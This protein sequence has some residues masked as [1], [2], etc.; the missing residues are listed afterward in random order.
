MVPVL[1]KV[2]KT[3]Y[4]QAGLLPYL[5][6]ES[7]GYRVLRDRSP[8]QTS[9]TERE[10]PLLILRC[11]GD[12]AGQVADALSVFC[13]QPLTYT[14][15]AGAQVTVD[16]PNILHLAVT[17]RPLAKSASS[18]AI[19]ETAAP[20]ATAAETLTLREIWQSLSGDTKLLGAALDAITRALP[21]ELVIPIDQGEELLTQVNSPMQQTRRQ[22]ALDMLMQLAGTAAR[23]KIVFTLRS[24]Y[25]GQLL[26]L[27][28][29]DRM[30]AG[31]HGFYL[32]PLTES[33]M[34]DA[35]LWPTNRDEVPYG[36]DV[37]YLRYRFVF[38]EGSAQQIVADAIEAADSAGHG[39]LPIVQAAGALLYQKQV[40][41]KRQQIV[42]VGDLK[43]SGG[44][45]N[46]LSKY[47]D[48]AVLKLPHGKQSQAALRTL[49]G[50]LYTSH[51]DGTLSRDLAPASDLKDYWHGST[52]VE[53]IVDEAA[54]KLGLFDIQR[55]FIGGEADTYVSLAQ[56]SLARLGRTIDSERDMEAYGK[57]KIIDTLWVMIP[58]AFLC[59]TLTFCL[60]R[61]YFPSQAGPM[62]AEIE[63]ELQTREQ[64]ARVE[65]VVKMRRPIYYGQLAQAE[66]ALQAENAVRARQI[67][68]SQPAMISF[69][70]KKDAKAA[71]LRGFEW[72]YLWKNLNGER[73]ALAGQRG[74]VNAVAVK[75]Q[76]V[77]TAGPTTESKN[78]GTIRIWNRSTGQVIALMPG[79]AAPVNALAFSHN[80]KLL[81]SAG[82]DKVVRLWDLSNFKDN[83]YIEI[84]KE[85]KV[86]NGHTD[87]VLA[88]DIYP[89]GE[90]LASASADKSVILWDV[91]SGKPRHT[92]K[93]H[94]AAVNAVV[95]ESKKTLAS[96]G[97]DGQLILWDTENGKKRQAIK[98]E[99]QTIAALA[100]PPGGK[101]VATGG[102]EIKDGV[103]Q[104]TIRLWQ[105]DDGKET[106][107]PI[108]HGASVR[109][110][111]YLWGPEPIIVSGGSDHVLRAFNV[112]TGK[113]IRRW[114]GHLGEI[115]SV[116]TLGDDIVTGSVDG[117][118]KVWD[119]RHASGP[120]VLHAHD[121]WVQA[122][123]LHRKN[124]LLA[125]GARDG[126]VKLWDPVNLRMLKELPKH[127]GAVTSVAFSHHGDR[128]LLAVGTR[129]AKNEGEI[130]IWQ[131]DIETATV[132]DINTLKEHTK[133]I[134][135]LA[136]NPH[137]DRADVL[138][139]GSAD[140]TVKVW[141]ITTGKAKTHARHKDE[142]RCVAFDADGKLFG[143]GGKDA[144]VCL[145]TLDKDQAWT[146]PDLHLNSVESI[147][148]VPTGITEQV[149]DLPIHLIT[150][151]ADLT[152]KRSFYFMVENGPAEQKA[153]LSS[154]PHSQPI[155]SALHNGA[156][157][158]D[159]LVTASWD[160][161][162]KL[163][164]YANERFTLL[165][166]HGAVRGIA[167][168]SDQSFLAS[169]GNDGTLRFWRAD[170][171]RGQPKDG[172]K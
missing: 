14:T 11:T 161:T 85:T 52:P 156:G 59:A 153:V 122:V 145:Y 82:A 60:T 37:P 58:L 18:T 83:E 80:A 140:H 4:L 19:Q 46:A 168:A 141:D 97:A 123:A 69:L 3:S 81:A 91:S 120:Q 163:Y 38:E 57:S 47:F 6:Q 63:K 144:L 53:D 162:I 124:S 61:N 165:G 42:R 39:P 45:R 86:L 142:V 160:G 146:I 106:G 64:Q 152:F 158:S 109:A 92:L 17:G 56:D 73:H 98:T 87:A 115:T 132:K 113:Q 23:C 8:Q 136:F 96:A 147:L 112:D 105:V 129:N 157:T 54:E 24:Q 149:S 7:V 62:E 119:S 26:S 15:P 143:S 9:V 121:D 49:I 76:Y 107:K 28:P 33:E 90:T 104:G 20:G 172:K 114:L 72:R 137:A 126:T 1:E 131:L 32:R 10:Y 138:L 22:K 2:G 48:L 13:A 21:F 36:D 93:E 77:A 167:M 5:E 75:G 166:H 151:S 27:L 128:T 71:D 66:Q 133:G 65:A 118:A 111:A 117:L 94:S 169:V 103:P 51:A 101:L 29:D 99:Y 127:A 74:A 116:A 110:L 130:K 50:K 12:L 67:L 159:L 34:V 44:V 139:S 134:T 95:F 125:T 154:R 171:E 55:L 89:D 155:T 78:D 41:D 68:F 43:D 135:C 25:L 16:L 30:P 84:T 100:K 102:V 88:L 70:E 148:L 108:H 35:L 170:Q 164:D 150:G 79:K 40:V 31:W